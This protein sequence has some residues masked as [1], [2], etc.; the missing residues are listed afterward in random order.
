M[1]FSFTSSGPLSLWTLIVSVFLTIPSHPRRHYY[2]WEGAE[3]SSDVYF[4]VQQLTTLRTM[5]LIA[6][7]N[8][9]SQFGVT[10]HVFT[11]IYMKQL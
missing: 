10:I 7:I 3:N 9:S 6:D 5:P 1:F 8:N 11:H 4:Y 2:I